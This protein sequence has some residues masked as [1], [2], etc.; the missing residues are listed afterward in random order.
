MCYQ[1]LVLYEVYVPSIHYWFV[2]FYL[3][4]FSRLEL[5][6]RGQKGTKEKE[7]RGFLRCDGVNFLNSCSLLNE[8]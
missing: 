4:I 8:D 3:S 2:F 5:R 6:D 1:I 7:I